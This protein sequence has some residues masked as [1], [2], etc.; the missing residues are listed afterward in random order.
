MIEISGIKSYEGRYK[1]ITYNLKIEKSQICCLI[2][3]DSAQKTEL[4]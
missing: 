2:G 3:T 1:E 4:I